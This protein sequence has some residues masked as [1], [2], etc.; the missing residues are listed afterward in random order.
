MRMIVVLTGIAL[1]AMAAGCGQPDGPT[2]AGNHP[3]NRRTVEVGMKEYAFVPGTITVRSGEQV[4]FILTN[5][6]QEDHEFEGE[7]VGIE[8]IVVPP[9]KKREMTW[10]AP[11]QPGTYEVVCDLP[12]H[13]QKGMVLKVTVAE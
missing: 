3:D 4:R 7:A 12:G 13:R 11:A 2:A 1:A 8:E 5:S 6:G 10:T 9:G